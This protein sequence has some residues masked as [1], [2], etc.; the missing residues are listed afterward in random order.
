MGN[1]LWLLHLYVWHTFLW[2]QWWKYWE[3]FIP[4]LTPYFYS[5]L[6]S[7]LCISGAPTSASQQQRHRC[8]IGMKTSIWHWCTF[9]VLYA[10]WPGWRRRLSDVQMMI[11]GHCKCAHHC[12]SVN[13]L[14]CGVKK[15]YEGKNECEPEEDGFQ[16]FFLFFFWQVWTRG[17][18]SV[19]NITTLNKN[20]QAMILASALHFNAEQS[21]SLAE[22]EGSDSKWITEV[23]IETPPSSL[24]EGKQSQWI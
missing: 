14:P 16:L 3:C 13:C 23:Q 1:W 21:R 12:F 19:F 17:G 7:A 22:T 4:H 20:Y 5:T 11:L 2:F 15:L 10:N 8:C 6:R 18:R 24:E 9:A